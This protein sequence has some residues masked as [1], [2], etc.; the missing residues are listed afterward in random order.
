MKQMK[1]QQPVGIVESMEKRLAALRQESV[2]IQFN[3][4]L[5]KT[6]R[7]LEK[8]KQELEVLEQD[9]ERNYA[10]YQKRMKEPAGTIRTTETTG[11]KTENTFQPHKDVPEQISMEFKVGAGIFSVV[12]ALFII[13][14]FMM[15]GTIYLQGSAG[16]LITAGVVFLANVALLLIPIKRGRNVANVVQLVGNTV[17]TWILALVTASEGIENSLILFYVISSVI[18]ANMLFRRLKKNA[19]NVTVYTTG[20]G[21]LGILFLFLS[22]RTEG[23]L[24]AF[25]IL[26]MVSLCFFFL[27]HGGICQWI[28]YWYACLMI[29]GYTAVGFG[30][31]QGKYPIPF[32]VGI[33]IVFAGAKLLSRITALRIS[34][35]LITLATA[36]CALWYYGGPYGIY[37]LAAF[38]LSILALYRDKLFYQ[39]VITLMS[40]SYF[41][42]HPFLIEFTGNIRHYDIFV[43]GVVSTLLIGMLLFNLVKPWRAQGI[44]VYNYCCLGCMGLLYLTAFLCTNYI[45][46]SILAVAGILTILVVLREKFGVRTKFNLL[47]LIL[48][49]VYMV[50]LFR[51]Q[52]PFQT[53][54]LLMGIAIF[55]VGAGFAVRRKSSRLCGLALSVFVCLKV[56]FYD[57]IEIPAQERIL[58]FFIVGMIAL[59]IGV[60]Y[61]LLEKRIAES[62]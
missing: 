47:F 34:E 39:I 50:F 56:V 60:I 59:A 61:I 7:Q 26:L 49:L 29:I 1:Q 17:I 19:V 45:A 30:P 15:F 52:I 11:I 4:Y 20:I 14:A 3:A 12:G 46:Y 10:V 43:A 33:L 5:E 40:A 18:I 37:F 24:A 9:I 13:A 42:W 55:S 51:I 8:Q 21:A 22:S 31:G 16:F 36:C 54:I 44:V 28:Q 32:L 35:M 41:V 57:F 23:T 27:E 53:S 25:G 6:A 38:L 48:F 62:K 58:V 2:E